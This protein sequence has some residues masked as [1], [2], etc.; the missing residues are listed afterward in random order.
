MKVL[1]LIVL[2]GIVLLVVLSN[3]SAVQSNY[4][5]LGEIAYDGSTQ[6]TTVYMQLEEYRWWVGLWGESDAVLVTEMPNEGLFEYYPRL[7]GS[8]IVLQISDGAGDL[9]GAFSKLS[10]MLTLDTAAGACNEID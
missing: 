1:G 6:P 4:E 7:V 2:L 8:D 5:C 3:F 10:H 9:K